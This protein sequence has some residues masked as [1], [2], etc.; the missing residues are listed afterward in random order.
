MRV[1]ISGKK[2]KRLCCYFK[3]WFCV[4]SHHCVTMKEEL[5]VEI[6]REASESR[7]EVSGGCLPNPCEGLQ[8]V[9]DS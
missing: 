7:G 9:V 4:A 2:S 3:L 8:G 5:I 6:K 1:I